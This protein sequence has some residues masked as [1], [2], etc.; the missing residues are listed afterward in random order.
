M[1]SVAPILSPPAD[2]V[3][4]LESLGVKEHA[5][6][7]IVKS[8]H[9]PTAAKGTGIPDE[10]YDDAV[11]ADYRTT[12]VIQKDPSLPAGNWDLCIIK[13]PG[14]CVGAYIAQ[15]AA[16]TNFQSPGVKT[17][18]T[19]TV[20]IQDCEWTTVGYMSTTQD[21]LVA[22]VPT[23]TRIAPQKYALN[24]PTSAPL[25]WRKTASSITAYMSA[26]AIADQGTV[27][28][29]QMERDY[30]YGIEDFGV[31]TNPGPGGNLLYRR[32]RVSVPLTETDMLL[33]DPKTYTNNARAGCYLPLRLGGPI[34]GFQKLVM[35]S[36]AP[37]TSQTAAI[38]APTDYVYYPYAYGAAVGPNTATPA[39]LVANPVSVQ[40]EIS[41]MDVNGLM[42]PSAQL[43]RPVDAQLNNEVVVDFGY[44]NVATSVIIFRGLDSSASITLKVYDSLEIVPQVASPFKQFVEEPAEFN[45]LA[46]HFYRHVVRACPDVYPADYNSWGKVWDVIKRVARE[47]WPVLKPAIPKLVDAATRAAS[48][49]PAAMTFGG[50]APPLVQYKSK[51]MA[52]PVKGPKR[53]KRKLA[54]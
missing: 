48:A 35:C 42:A 15:G 9:P 51:S 24:A 45:P 33:I 47:V 14:D 23:L 11:N 39:V 13:P 43:P 17:T 32:A 8:L 22:A 50:R 41:G 20:K 44:D 31:L 46:L 34:Q 30:V 49:A 1:S 10:S 6:K 29:A 21:V 28:A 5:L 19:T 7:W 25:M 40:A 27:Y 38:P 26:S 18:I 12:S 3:R 36:G 16:G 52:P 37:F 53:R 54:T 4:H 2:V